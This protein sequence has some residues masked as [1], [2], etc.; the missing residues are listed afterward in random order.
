MADGSDFPSYKT[1]HVEGRAVGGAM[2]PMMA[3]IPPHWNVYFNV[4]DVDATAA[5]AESL[6]GKA[7]APAFDVPEIGRLAGVA[8]PSGATFWLMGP[9][10][11]AA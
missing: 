1:M 11:D 4:T 9:S 2:P 5:K 8:D 6:G 3:G 10:P 7:F